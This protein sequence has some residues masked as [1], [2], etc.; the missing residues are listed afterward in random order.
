VH[1]LAAIR[2]GLQQGEFFLEYLPTIS[3]SDG[4]CLGA[5]A[6]VRWRTPTGVI[7]PGEFIPHAEKTPVA[8]LITYWVMETIEAELGDWLP[9]NPGCQISFNV[10]PQLLGRGGLEYTASR[11]GLGKHAPQLIFEITERGL[12]DSLGLEAINEGRQAGILVALD[13]VTFMGGANV[14]VLARCDFYAIKLDKLLIDQ[15]GPESSPPDWLSS[16]AALLKSSP[17]IVIAE[18]VETEQQAAALRSAN[19]QAA[20]GFYYSRPIPADAFK[21]FFL[22]RTGSKASAS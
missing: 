6:L 18:G 3:L 15:I 9:A 19:I 22:S 10:P 14:A 1:D 12:P 8:G 13:D 11:S 21:A 4:R 5:E 7:P 2:A 20:Q 16:A 17:M